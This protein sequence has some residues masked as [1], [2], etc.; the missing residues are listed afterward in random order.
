MSELVSVRVDDRT[1]EVP[2]GTGLVEAAQAAGIEIPVFCYEPRLGPPVG[3]CR[4]CLVEIEGIPKLQA[5]CT[6]TVAPD[7]VIK[8]S[9]TSEKAAEG[10]E[11]TLEFILVN[12]PLDCPV[13][14][15]GGECPLQDLTFRYGPGNTRMTLQKHTFDKPIPVSPL[16]A[17]DRERCI[18]CYRCTRFSEDVA[19]DGQLIA[20]NRGRHTE[21]ATFEDEPYRSPFSGNV[22]E[23]CPVGALTSTLYRFEARPWDIQ[24]VPTVCT[25]CAVG[26]NTSATIREGKV[27]RIHSRNHPEVDRGWLCDKGRFSYPHLRAEDRI[28]T[29]LRRGRKG[30]EEISWDDALDE[31]ES[32]LRAAGGSIVTAFSGS[33]TTELA[34]ALGRLLRGGLDA[35]S[36]V[37]PE[38]TSDALEAFRLPLSAIAE[39]EVVVVVGDDPIVERAPIVDLWI[40]QARRHGA[41]VHVFSPSGTEQ[42]P[43]GAAA[44]TCRE[45]SRSRG[46]IA[47][48]LRTAER[49]VLVWSGPGGGGG[50]RIAELA[51][52]LGFA[53]KP[54][55]GAF[56]LPRASNARGVAL[57][58]AVAS[59]A[60]ETNPEPIELLVVSGD[61]AASNPDVRALAEQASRVLVLTMFHELAAG[62]A[63]LILPSTAA[64]ERDGTSM[65]LEGRVQRVRRTVPP[66]CP[67]ELAWISKLA[68]RFDV[69]VPAHAAGVFAELA[70]DLFRDLT[71]DELGLHAPLPARRAY[72]EPAAAT[73]PDHADDTNGALRLHRYTPLFSGPAVERVPE[74]DFQRP[75]PHVELSAADASRLGIAGG[76]AVTVRSNGT[77]V[78]LRARIDRKLIAGVVR[79]AE[80]HAGELHP[81]VEVTKT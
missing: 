52:E 75:G 58:W 20:R 37:L 42:T 81:A 61:E 59:D 16:I 71:L 26:C 38:A 23:L 29:P 41:E 66:P 12:H 15:K 35:H 40:K 32:M 36:A 62:W 43:P 9:A 6:L 70:E 46:A 47:T 73:T 57:G 18:L 55:C 68:E 67:D 44:E 10:Q 28:T 19:E 8:T 17:L 22:I 64:L 74:L 79:V 31:A 39:A 54:G 50:A 34:Y 48:K 1:V 78:E 3:A 65:N 53:E 27:K 49:A 76:D 60:D 69:D 2:K 63:D 24:N 80:E 30:L 72:I 77:S 14:D 51:H 45:L 5:A 56:H 13:C 25:G 4:M 33:E 21:I 7:M 11:A